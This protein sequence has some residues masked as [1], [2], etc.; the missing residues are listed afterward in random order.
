MNIPQ[1]GNSQPVTT[2]EN[3]K[4]TESEKEYLGDPEYERIKKE[5]SLLV[6]KLTKYKEHLELLEE[7][8]PKELLATASELS[9]IERDIDHFELDERDLTIHEKDSLLERQRKVATAILKKQ[10]LSSYKLPVRDEGLKEHYENIVSLAKE[11]LIHEKKSQ[12]SVGSFVQMQSKTR[13]M[14]LYE[15]KLLGGN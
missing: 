2:P 8:K 4:I 12:N 3:E 15:Q 6:E 7:S 11:K 10:G 1:K 9:Q 5:N 13:A 14:R